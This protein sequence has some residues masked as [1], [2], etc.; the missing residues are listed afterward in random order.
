MARKGIFSHRSDFELRYCPDYNKLA[1]QVKHIRESHGDTIV[2]TSGVWDLIHYGHKLY[3]EKA[4]DFGDILIVGVD[5]D[6]LTR[7][8]KKVGEIERPIVGFEERARM[9]AFERPVD[10]ITRVDIGMLEP[11]MAIRPDV[12]VVS[13]TTGDLPPEEYDKFRPYVGRIEPLKPQTPPDMVST[14]ARIRGML[15]QGLDLAHRE[16]Q[17][18]INDVFSKLRSTI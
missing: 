1:E 5:T 4:R 3:L 11:V 14:T 13:T 18:A 10:L 9:L 6:E 7:S 8:R 17:T 15:I 12:L 2:F 16:L